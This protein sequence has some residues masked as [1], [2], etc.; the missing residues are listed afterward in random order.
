MDPESSRFSTADYSFHQDPPDN[1]NFEVNNNSPNINEPSTDNISENTSWNS[2][3]T[4][5]TQYFPLH[6]ADKG[7]HIKIEF[8]VGVTP[9]FANLPVFLRRC[10]LM[11]LDSIGS[12]DLEDTFVYLIPTD[13]FEKIALKQCQIRENHN[14]PYSKY[15]F[16]E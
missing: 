15:P 7:V 2:L 11:T 9:P 8:D 1:N 4:L 3:C 13:P 5:G 6:F 16:R 10:Q 14:Y 12:F